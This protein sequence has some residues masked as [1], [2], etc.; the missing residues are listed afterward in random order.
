MKTK[1][2]SKS[3]YFKCTTVKPAWVGAFDVKSE[4]LSTEIVDN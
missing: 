3:A 2:I 4:G 1:G